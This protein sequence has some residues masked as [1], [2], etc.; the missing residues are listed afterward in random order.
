[1]D[2]TLDQG[3]QHK[4]AVYT[5]ITGSYDYLKD[6]EYRMPDCDYIC[7]T[8]QSDL[9]SDVW[10]I[11]YE[12]PGQSDPVRWQR[13]HKILA[14]Q[15]LANEYEWCIY[16][17]GNVRITGDFREYICQESKGAPLLCLKHP[18][19]N[20]IYDEAEECI[21]LHKDDPDTIRRQ[22]ERYRREAYGT[23]RGLVTTNVLVRKHWDQMVM[24]VMELWWKEVETGSRR[25]QLSFNYACWK[26]GV[27]YDE[28]ELKCWK[29][30]YW[31]NPGIHT[32]DISKVEEELVAHIQLEAYMKYQM[33]EKDTYI[34]LK[35]RELKDARTQLGWKEQE[36]KDMCTQMGWKEQELKDMRTQIDWKE[37]ELKDVCT[38]MG[39]KE[40]ELKDAQT[41][42]GWKEQELKDAQTVLGWKEQELKDAQIVL[43]WKEQELKQAKHCFRWKRKDWCKRILKNL[44]FNPAAVNKKRKG[45]RQNGENKVR[46]T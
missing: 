46:R 43:G 8:D 5:V 40:Q 6:P 27:M 23:G 11:R 4:I 16:V 13:R 41:M 44:R 18:D 24:R 35:E 20:C 29:S 21:R 37:Q 19:R 31:L 38:Q 26:L 7:F 9:Q 12:P 14:H 3:R 15:Y 2:K 45:R 36:L 10:E 22:M 39:W 33:R 32:A 25:D 34:A 42:L 28:S 30:P 1:M 17:D